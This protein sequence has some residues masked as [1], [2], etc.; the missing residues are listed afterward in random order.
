MKCKK[1]HTGA[2]CAPCAQED[3]DDDDDEAD[4][5]AADDD[6]TIIPVL[7]TYLLPIT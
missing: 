4:D 1:A 2:Q 3:A 5:Y 7:T 6:D